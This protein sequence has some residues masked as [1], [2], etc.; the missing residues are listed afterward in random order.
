MHHRPL[1]PVVPPCARDPGIPAGAHHMHAIDEL[2]ASAAGSLSR[3]RIR[4]SQPR[5]ADCPYP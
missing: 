4:E 3:P 1:T 5:H 2:R